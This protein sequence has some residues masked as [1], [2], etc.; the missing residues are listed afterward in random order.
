M[1][2]ICQSRHTNRLDLLATG[3][4]LGYF[5]ASPFSMFLVPDLARTI[6]SL[7]KQQFQSPARSDVSLTVVR[8]ASEIARK[9][10]LYTTVGFW[11][12]GMT[13]CRKLKITCQ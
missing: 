9:N 12:S 4:V 7:S 3:G 8:S 1:S 6:R 2:E 5:A 11:A 13:S 10:T